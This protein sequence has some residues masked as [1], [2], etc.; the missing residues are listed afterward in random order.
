MQKTKTQAEKRKL[1]M[2]HNDHLVV[3]SDFDGTITVQDTGIEIIDHCIGTAR[4]KALDRAVLD[5]TLTFREAIA[6]M[7]AGVDMPFDKAASL[8]DHVVLDAGFHAFHRAMASRGIPINVVSAGITPICERFLAPYLNPAPAGANATVRIFANEIDTREGGWKIQFRDDSEFGHDKGQQLRLLKEERRL[9]PR[10]PQG[11]AKM[12]D[13]DETTPEATT[14]S[15]NASVGDSSKSAWRE[16][17]RGVPR[18]IL[19]FIGD[20]VSD[21]SAAK[22]ADVLFVK[23]GTNL[24]KWCV[25]HGVAYEPWTSFDSI[26]EWA[27]RFLNEEEDGGEGQE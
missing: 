26:T 8:L 10:P 4:R 9:R 19:M 15:T 14:N 27:V 7:W 23:E 20:G 24:E 11:A 18:P 5:G 22:E 13:S 12:A 16:R 25:A 3:F 2:Q 17:L 1:K 21:I 6:T